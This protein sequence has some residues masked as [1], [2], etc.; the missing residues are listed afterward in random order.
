MLVNSN[1][2]IE[3]NEKEVLDWNFDEQ[4]GRIYVDNPI[5]Y[6]Y[7]RIRRRGWMDD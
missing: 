7:G 1:Q 3:A 2:W 4:N 5:W 6:E